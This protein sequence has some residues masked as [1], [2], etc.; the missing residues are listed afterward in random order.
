M[1]AQPVAGR[2]LQ[3]EEPSCTFR[4]TTK[5]LNR[6]EKSN[7]RQNSSSSCFPFCAQELPHAASNQTM[8]LLNRPTLQKMYDINLI[9]GGDR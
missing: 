9:C 1:A 2:L 7:E 3:L 4:A 5:A 8:K 6:F